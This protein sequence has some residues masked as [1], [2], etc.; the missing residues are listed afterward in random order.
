MPSM[1]FISNWNRPRQIQS[2]PQ[3]QVIQQPIV[4]TQTSTN[5]SNLRDMFHAIRTGEK[6]CKA[7]GRG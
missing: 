7:C 1:F 3:T 4:T 6:S 5:T 2:T